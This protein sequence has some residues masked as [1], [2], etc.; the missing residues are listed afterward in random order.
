MILFILLIYCWFMMFDL[1]LE[2]IIIF[3]YFLNVLSWYD[4]KL[5]VVGFEYMFLRNFLF[6][7]V[8]LLF[9]V[10]NI[11][12]LFL[13]E[14]FNNLIRNRLFIIIYIF[15][16]ILGYFDIKDFNFLNRVLKKFLY[17]LWYFWSFFILKIEYIR[18]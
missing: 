1:F 12:I 3:M 8:W 14:S 5:F 9:G 18:I 7:Y 15:M 13:V 2:I 10:Y 17:F 11:L 4:L 6:L 16:I